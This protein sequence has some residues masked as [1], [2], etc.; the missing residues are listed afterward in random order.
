[1]SPRPLVDA[2]YPPLIARLLAGRGICSPD[3]AEEFLDAGLHRLADPRSL[4]GVNEAVSRIVQALAAR[5]TIGVFGDYDVDGQTATALM[6][7]VLEELG[8]T[9]R[10]YIPHRTK[11][12]Y[13]LNIPALKELVDLGCRLVIT[14]D[15]GI[16][17]LA[18]AAWAA[19]NGL[20]LIITDHHQPPDELPQAVAIINPLLDPDYPTQYLAGCGVAFK[21]A[22]A[23]A[24]AATGTRDLAHRLVELVAIGTV[25]D[26]VPL[27]GEN[28]SLVKAGLAKLNTNGVI[29]GL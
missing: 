29:P 3:Q 2:G 28:R 11:E 10:P 1:M 7:R 6:V 19:E 8:A 17:A 24:E 25:A 4:K 13:G 20:D 16:S 23:L 14:V 5:E 15:C 27:L 22:E 21:L 12:G 18:E 9:V 26:V